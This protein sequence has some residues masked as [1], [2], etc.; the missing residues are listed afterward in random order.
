MSELALSILRVLHQHY[1][2]NETLTESHIMSLLGKGAVSDLNTFDAA[3]KELA[4]YGYIRYL[5]E[6]V[7]QILAFDRSMS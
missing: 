2:V 7:W 5:T 1:L 4:S 3:T 6:D